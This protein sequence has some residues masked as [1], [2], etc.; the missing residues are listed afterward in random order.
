MTY[1][2]LNVKEIEKFLNF[3]WDDSEMDSENEDIDEGDFLENV[4]QQTLHKMDEND[5]DIEL[6]EKVV[7]DGIE[8]SSETINEETAQVVEKINLDSLRWRSIGMNDCDTSWKNEVICGESKDPLAYFVDF[9]DDEI[10]QKICAETNIY[11]MQSSGL[12]LKCEPYEIKRFIGV[13]LY[14]GAVK[15]PQ[16]RMAWAK[17]FRHTAITE[18]FVRNRFEKIKQYFHINDNSTQP[19]KGDSNYDKL[20]KV[21]PLLDK[22]KEKYNQIPQEE[23]QSIDEQIIAYKGHNSM[24]QY[25]PK[26]PHKWGF[27]M[28]T[29]AG[30]SGIMYDFAL[31]VGEGTCPSYGL[32]ISSDIVLFCLQKFLIMKISNCF[33]TIGSPRLV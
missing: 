30:A 24:K 9:F 7:G 23:Y 20:H 5:I 4:I 26:K 22:F 32:G 17:N 10:I 15:I 1:K 25:L 16:M 18:S 14:L 3:D 33:S 12:E 31:Y 11:A 21:R 6:I 19:Q 28:F 8:V 27:K 29:R 2:S 13:L